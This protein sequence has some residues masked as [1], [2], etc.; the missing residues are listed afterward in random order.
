MMGYF[1]I[2]AKALVLMHDQNKC[3]LSGAYVT[4]STAV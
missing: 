3:D 4:V 1:K 2:L